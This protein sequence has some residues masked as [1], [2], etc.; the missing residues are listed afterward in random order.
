MWSCAVVEKKIS[1]YRPACRNYNCVGRANK[2]GTRILTADERPTMFYSPAKLQRRR[3][4]SLSKYCI[5]SKELFCSKTQKK[6]SE[7]R[8]VGK[9][10]VSKCKAR[11]SP[12]H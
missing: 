11:G 12:E 7:E 10:C 3:D 4:Q 9:E 8:R 1:R 5:S 2:S 6:E